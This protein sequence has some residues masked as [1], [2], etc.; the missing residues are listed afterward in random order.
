MNKEAVIIYKVEFDLTK[1]LRNDAIV[2]NSVCIVPVEISQQILEQLTSEIPYMYKGWDGNVY[3]YYKQSNPLPYYE[4]K[5]AYTILTFESDKSPDE[6][7]LQF[8][9]HKLNL[10]NEDLNKDY[11]SSVPRER[12]VKDKEYVLEELRKLGWDEV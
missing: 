11:L 2:E 8:L 10:C 7:R 6:L 1:S 4:S 5:L 3:P 9:K 12:I